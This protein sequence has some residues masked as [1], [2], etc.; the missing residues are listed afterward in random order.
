MA[1]PSELTWAVCLS[2]SILYKQ[3]DDGTYSA[4]SQGPE[5]QNN[6]MVSHIAW[7]C[8]FIDVK[9]NSTDECR[10]LYMIFHSMAAR[11]GMFLEPAR[12]PRS[13]STQSDYDN[14]IHATSWL[15]ILPP[16]MHNDPIPCSRSLHR[17]FGLL[18]PILS[19]DQD[20]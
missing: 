2:I 11:I 15:Q 1:D 20:L 3:W 13:N 12:P 6:A 17:S 14:G 4:H 8:L 10:I 18:H 16:V 5:S 19:S 9:T 7:L